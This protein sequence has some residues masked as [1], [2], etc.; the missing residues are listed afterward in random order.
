MKIIGVRVH[1]KFRPEI[2]HELPFL[3]TY[4]DAFDWLLRRYLGL[5]G[6]QVFLSC[7]ARLTEMRF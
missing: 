4:L 7:A 5:K 6:L 3:G 2:E 1:R